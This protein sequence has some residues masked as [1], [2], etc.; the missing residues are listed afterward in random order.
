MVG[1]SNAAVSGNKNSR[2]VCWTITNSTHQKA[3]RRERDEDLSTGEI[4]SPGDASYSIFGGTNLQSVSARLRTRRSDT[5]R[6]PAWPLP[7]R[8][9]CPQSR[10]GAPARTRSSHG[11][12]RK[13]TRLNSSHGYISYAV[14]CLKKK[15]RISHGKTKEYFR[16]SWRSSV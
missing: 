13:S 1:H 4:M 14:F 6:A 16:D 9:P 3:S 11:P 12:D 15:N 7:P 10:R 2:S 5:S 8:L